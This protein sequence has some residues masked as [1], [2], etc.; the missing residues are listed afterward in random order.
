M[1]T[2]DR[3]VWMRRADEAN[4]NVLKNLLGLRDGK[5]PSTP[6][7]IGIAIRV[8]LDELKRTDG[9]PRQDSSGPRSWEPGWVPPAGTTHIGPFTTS[10]YMHSEPESTP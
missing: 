1:R 9:Y 8:S 10:A 6:D 5:T 2:K 7:A 4:L 3:S